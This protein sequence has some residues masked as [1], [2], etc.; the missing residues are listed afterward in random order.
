[1]EIIIHGT[2]KMG[3]VLLHTIEELKEDKITGFCDELTDE[4]GD[5]I[6]DFSHFSRIE[7]ELLYAKE[8]KI[9]LVIGTTGYSDEIYEKIKE[10]SKYIP[11]LLASNM[12]LGVNVFAEVLKKVV[13]LL[14]QNFDIEVIETHHNKKIDAPSGTAKTLINIIKDNSKKE[15]HEQY[16]RNGISKRENNEIGVHSLRGGTVAGEHS[17]IFYG[18]DEVFEIKHK[19]FS[20]KIFAKGAIKGANLLLN[21][22]NGLYSI[23]DLMNCSHLKPSF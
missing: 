19:A 1:M 21:R 12:S 16:G 11:I 2:G 5:I 14:S 9:P 23:N 7:N 17:V 8:H 10:T 6:I 18:D 22:E 3:H 15:L 20:K 13:P 4:K